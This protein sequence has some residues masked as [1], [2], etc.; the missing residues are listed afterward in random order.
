VALGSPAVSFDGL[1]D[2]HRSRSELLRLIVRLVSSNAA[3]QVKAR[4]RGICS[5]YIFGTTLKANEV[6]SATYRDFLPDAW[7]TV[8]TSPRPSPPSSA[9]A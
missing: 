7:P 9:T 8:A 6:A 3:L 1:A 5:K 2:G 4:S